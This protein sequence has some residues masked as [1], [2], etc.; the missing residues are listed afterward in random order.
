MYKRLFLIFVFITTTLIQ[1]Q[2]ATADF[3]IANGS[4]TEDAW[5]VYSTW[6]DAGNGWPA[7][8]RTQGWYKIEPGSFRN[9]SVPADNGYVYIRVERPGGHEIEPPDHATRNNY[10][11][12]IHPSQVFTTVETVN[13]E[14]LNSN[15]NLRNLEQGALY[16][17]RNGDQHIITETATCDISQ[18]LPVDQLYTQAMRS[19]VWILNLDEESQGSG[20]LID[21]ERKLVVTNQHV[22]DNAGFVFVSFPVQDQDRKLIGDRNYYLENYLSL[23]LNG[24]GTWARVIAE[25]AEKDLAILQLDFLPENSLEI[26]HDLGENIS[27][28]MRR[29]E[30]VH[31]LGNPGTLEL[32]RWTLGLFHADAGD[33]L[34][35]NADVYG[36]NSGGPVLNGKGKLIGIISLSD[37]RTRTWAVPARYVKDLLDTVK[38]GHTFRIKNDDTISIDYHI[39]WSASDDWKLY[40]V[41]PNS[42]RT[43]WLNVSTVPQ[44]YPKIAFDTNRRDQQTT[45][46][47]YELDTFLRYFGDNYGDRVSTFDV[48]E[49]V[50]D[51]NASTQKIELSRGN[52]SCVPADVN[53]DGKTD[54]QDLEFI[55]ARIGTSWPGAADTDRDDDVDVYDI[56]FAAGLLCDAASAPSLEP[57]TF[58]TLTAENLQRWITQAKQLNVSDPAF[59]KG[60]AF[61]EELLAT[62]TRVAA[63]SVETSLLPNYPNPFNPET[64][65]PYKLSKPA[66]VTVTIYAA[67]GQLIRTLVLGHQPMGTYQSKSRAAY[68]DGRNAVGEPAASGVYFYTLTAGDFSATRKMLIL[69]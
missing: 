66:E 67:D 69:K 37:R 7:G 51:Y 19:V 40:S 32:W 9:L 55:A 39:K 8:F 5:V 68:W 62:L 22:T 52:N 26:D 30:L 25:D 33:W 28:N 6:R 18:N 64:W 27:S 21:K 11:F 24:Y 47:F 23:A 63:T 42:S 46:Q 43:H 35:I 48:Y 16:A 1:T 36:G 54:L 56:I 65:I 2:L 13:G 50:F 59:Q 3:L 34:E 53:G 17:Y 58:P 57:E 41:R 29:D 10:Q 15:F 49:Y 14:F 20:V 44:N 12:W 61:L 38:P 4:A 45:Y 60:I 31:I